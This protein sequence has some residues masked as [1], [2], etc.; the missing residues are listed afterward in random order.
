MEI[1]ARIIGGV[2]GF[3]IA[4]VGYFSNWGRM[5]DNPNVIFMARILVMF[6]GS[7]LVWDTVTRLPLPFS[8][9]KLIGTWGEL[10]AACAAC[11]HE[12]KLKEKGL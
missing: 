3:G 4:A 5:F 11:G 1:P 6:M 2:I 12:W 10:H 9:I 8:G 7:W